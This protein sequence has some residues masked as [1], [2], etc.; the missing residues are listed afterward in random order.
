MKQPFDF[1][2]AAPPPLDGR[3]LRAELARRRERRAAALLAAGSL[4][5][6]TCLALA[7]VPLRIVAPALAPLAAAYVCAA[8][9]GGG[10][11]AILLIHQ[12]RSLFSWR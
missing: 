4:L 2:G 11:L 9:S 8:A 5:A 7:A 1:T 6:L 3:A 10:V 12:R